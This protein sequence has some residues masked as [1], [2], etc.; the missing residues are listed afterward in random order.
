LLSVTRALALPASVSFTSISLSVLT[1]IYSQQYFIGSFSSIFDS[2][3]PCTA[4]RFGA[5]E[6]ELELNS[7][8]FFRS[9]YTFISAK[10]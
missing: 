2:D 4:F 9:V 5:T 1:G 10:A 8:S 3:F 6:E 7:F